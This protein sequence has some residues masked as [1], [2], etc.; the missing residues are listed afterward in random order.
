VP[1]PPP[2]P[3]P[4]P[5]HS[6][7]HFCSPFS[8]SPFYSPFHLP[9]Y[10]PFHLPYCSN[11]SKN[12]A[13]HNRNSHFSVTSTCKKYLIDQTLTAVESLKQIAENGTPPTA[14]SVYEKVFKNSLDT[15]ICIGMFSDPETGEFWATFT[16][17][18]M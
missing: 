18:R 4:Q 8:S 11:G 2:P 17:G 16:T 15:V 9:F 10:S 3:P 6:H 13:A 1:P 14:E 5:A 7:T 12:Q